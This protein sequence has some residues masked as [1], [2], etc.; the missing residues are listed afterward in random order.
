MYETCFFKKFYW[1]WVLWILKGN[2]QY[3]YA[4]VVDISRKRQIQIAGFDEKVSL[5][6]IEK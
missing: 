6:I 2:L 1:Y 3:N 5:V 4:V